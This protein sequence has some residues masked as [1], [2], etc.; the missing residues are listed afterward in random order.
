MP[1]WAGVLTEADIQA[2]VGHIRELNSRQAEHGESVSASRDD[3][4]STLKTNLYDIRVESIVEQGLDQPKSLAALPDGRLLVTDSKGLR[5]I[6]NGQLAHE[7]VTGIPANDSLEEIARHPS[8]GWF[9]LTYLCSKACGHEN[10]HTYTLARGHLRDARWTDNEALAD[11]GD[12]DASYGVSKIAFD[13]RGHVFLTL[14]GAERP[15]RD[16]A[17]FEAE[18]AKPQDLGSYRGKVLRLQED[19]RIPDDNPFARRPGALPAIWSYGHRGLSGLYFDSATQALWATEHGPWGGDELNRIHAGGNYGWPVVSFG[20]HYAGKPIAAAQQ[21]GMQSPVFH[22]SPSIGV[23]NVLVYDGAAFP[24]WRGQVFV[25][26]LGARIGRTL[27]RFEL[28][29]GR[30]LLYAYPSD[31]QGHVLRDEAGNAL[32]RV[33]RYEEVAPDIGRIR[34]M[35][36]GPQGYLYLLLEHPDRVVRLAPA[37][38]PVV[39]DRR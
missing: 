22:W 16:P 3:A 15:G 17:D 25:G 7:V 29:E 13:D 19:G 1:A 30:A 2:L 32:P 21:A 6:R 9:Y 36:V 27:F 38:P 20:H 10:R 39:P 31:A 24:N 28:K 23:S 26:S 34:D 37:T 8:N 35:R 5:V 33:P 14:S 18:I 4:P 11:F 12:G